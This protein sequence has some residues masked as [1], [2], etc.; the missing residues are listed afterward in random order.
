MADATSTQA[1]LPTTGN[2]GDSLTQNLNVPF[3]GADMVW[4]MTSSALVWIMI[5]G[6]GLLYS[7]MS[8]KH[9]ALSPLWAS[10]MCCA[11]VSFEWFFWG[12]TLA[13]SHKAGKFIGTMDNFGLINVLAAPSVGSSAV[14]DI[15]YMFY[16]GMFACITGMLMVGG[17]HERARLG[18]M[19]VYLFIWMTVVYSPIACWTWNPS[20]WL[21]VLGGLDFAGGGPVHMSSGAGALAYALWCGKRRDPAVE[22][23]PHYR[24][25]S[26]TSVVLGTVLLWFG[27]FGFNGGSSGNAS[28]RGFYAAANTNLAAACGALAWM[29]V[30]FFRKGRK[31]STVGLCS[32]AIA[33]L[34][35]I[36]PAAGF[37]PIW[38]A[39]PIGIITAVF[40]NISGDLKNLL[41]I[42][43]GLDVF[44]LHGVGGF[45]GSVLTAFFAADYI[46][47]LDG[48]TEIKGGWLNHHWAQ[49]GYQLAGAFATLGY[50]FVVSSVILVIMNRIPYLNVRMTE[51][52]EMLG[53]DMA[54]IGEFAFDWEDSGVLDL[55]GQNP[56][57]MGVTPNVQTPKPSSINENKEAAESDSV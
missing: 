34:V 11:L 19:M 39:V 30:D 45:C 8:R 6:V 32:G 43:D 23:L 38:S 2:G 18:P 21:A 15:L 10:I 35:G 36:T 54:Q 22:K 41:R 52:E 33:G 16:Q 31:W 50:S 25:S 53:T 14:P 51:E 13:F 27:W 4:I 7:G 46:A 57:G 48:A 20:G 17:A 9:H 47:H 42:D 28:I 29:C 26:V 12:Y 49:L 24:P 37:V 3:L 1:P 55:H 5:P 40:A 44:S 56:N